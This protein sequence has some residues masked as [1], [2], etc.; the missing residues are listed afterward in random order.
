VSTPR[1]HQFPFAFLDIAA[2]LRGGKIPFVHLDIGGTAVEQADWQF[3]KPTG[4]PVATLLA[5]LS[6]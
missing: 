2:G 4:T 6:R 3:G 1:G 5:Y